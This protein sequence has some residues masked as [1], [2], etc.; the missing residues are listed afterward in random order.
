MSDSNNAALAVLL[1]VYSMN[2]DSDLQFFLNMSSQL[3]NRMVSYERCDAYTQIKP[4]E[5][6]ELFLKRNRE[7]MLN[8]KKPIRVPIENWPL[9]GEIKF[10]NYSVKYRANL[11]CAL[12]DLNVTI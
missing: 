11:K 3:E 8:C 2:I 5:G 9:F 6:Y 4:E 12:E 7:L 1:L 10:K